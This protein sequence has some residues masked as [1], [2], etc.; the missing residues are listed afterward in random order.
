MRRVSQSATAIKEVLKSHAWMDLRH[1]G[2]ILSTGNFVARF[3]VFMTAGAMFSG[4]W[5]R[6]LWYKSAVI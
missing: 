4:T 1:S 6:D 5:R 2:R 3:E